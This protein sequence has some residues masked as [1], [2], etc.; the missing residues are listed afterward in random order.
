VSQV[1]PGQTLA[2]ARTFSF[3]VGAGKALEVRDRFVCQAVRERN[4]PMVI[5]LGG[6]DIEHVSAALHIKTIAIARTGQSAR[7]AA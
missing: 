4:I 5:N 6:G 2:R 1:P 7:R 3:L